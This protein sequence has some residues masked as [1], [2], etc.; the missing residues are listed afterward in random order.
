[1]VEE[2]DPDLLVLQLLAADELGHVAGCAASRVDAA[3]PGTPARA[4]HWSRS[5][6][7]R[8]LL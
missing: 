2:E 7:A 4:S 5:P 6:T 1:M 8:Q 3:D